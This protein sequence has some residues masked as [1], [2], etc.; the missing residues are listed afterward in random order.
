[1]VAEELGKV[2]HAIIPLWEDHMIKASL[3][4]RAR[5]SKK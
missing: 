5:P 4:Y 1:M 3:N 2:V